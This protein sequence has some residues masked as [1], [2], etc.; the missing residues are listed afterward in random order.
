MAKEC[1]P[2][3]TCQT[4]TCWVWAS[5]EKEVETI[6]AEMF[7]EA[8]QQ[9]PKK[10][11]D[12]V[13]LVDGNKT[14]IRLLEK[15]A[16]EEKVKVTIIVDIIHVLEYLW[17]AAYASG[18]QEAQNWVSDKLFRILQ[19][20]SSLMAAGMRRQATHAKLTEEKRTAVDDCAQYL[21]NYKPYLTGISVRAIRLRVIEGVCRY[22]IK[23]R[24][25]RTGARWSLKGAEAILK[26]RSLVSSGDLDAYWEFH[27]SQEKQRHY[28]K[29]RKIFTPAQLPSRKAEKQDND[30]QKVA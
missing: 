11:K 19:G 26:L 28:G 4:Q 10:Q 7:T 13:A 17:K 29:I 30:S 22:L 16:K 5:A 3:D 20:K 18:T 25:D 27:D 2:Y 15:K 24:M 6:V 1:Y 12:W 23:D 8:L 14:Q 9:D 21:L